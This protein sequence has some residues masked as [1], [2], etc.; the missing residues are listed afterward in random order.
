MKRVILVLAM[1][2]AAAVGCTSNV[3]P[4]NDREAALDA[5]APAAAM[6]SAGAAIAGV[7]T[8]LLKPEIMTDADLASLAAESGRCLFR[9]TEIG[10]PVLVYSAT[11]PSGIIKL[12]GKLISLARTGDGSYE[13]DG[14]SIRIRP[15]SDQI[16]GQHPAEMVMRL[17]GASNE[18]GFRGF[19][20]CGR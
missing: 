9:M 14:V 8:G 12:N 16:S 19:S 1:L 4:G 7:E 3:A 15:L 18:L 20:A 13:S 17:P 11:G 2:A 10:F 6:E 5:T